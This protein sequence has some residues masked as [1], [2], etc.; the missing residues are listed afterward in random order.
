MKEICMKIENTLL[1]MLTKKKK[2][3]F[4]SYAI[5]ILYCTLYIY[6]LYCNTS[7]FISNTWVQD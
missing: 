1:C 7:I 4:M 5:I 2:K 3:W 6:I